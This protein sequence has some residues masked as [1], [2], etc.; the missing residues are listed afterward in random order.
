MERSRPECLSLHSKSEL[1]HNLH[2]RQRSHLENTTSSLLS[3]H[4][5]LTLLRSPDAPY[6]RLSH[7]AHTHLLAAFHWENTLRGLV[8]CCREEHGVIFHSEHPKAVRGHEDGMSQ[9]NSLL[10]TT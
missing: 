7:L 4:A 9:S 10:E 8:H 6:P 1:H 5:L 3:L 2:W